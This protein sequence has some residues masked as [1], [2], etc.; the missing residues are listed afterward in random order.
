[1][2]SAPPTYLDPDAHEAG[3][4]GR[5]A[6]IDTSDPSRYVDIFCDCHRYTEPKILANGIDIA[7]PAGWEEAQAME[8]RRAHGLQAPTLA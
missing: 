5:S 4:I 1:M 7:W 8:W 2:S 6:E 3:C